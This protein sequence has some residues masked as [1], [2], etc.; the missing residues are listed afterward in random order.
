MDG[1]SAGRSGAGKRPIVLG[2]VLMLLLG[3]G[4]AMVASRWGWIPS[5][6]NNTNAGA[7]TTPTPLASPSPA[8]SPASTPEKA[9]RNPKKEP[10]PKKEKQSKL[11]AA[12]GKVK[13]LFKKPF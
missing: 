8:A 6:V 13:K 5:G 3:L 4:L 7:A 10:T 2:A 11:G 12:F 9:E 1:Q